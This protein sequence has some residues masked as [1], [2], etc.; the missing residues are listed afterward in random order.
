MSSIMLLVTIILSKVACSASNLL[1]P[2]SR[3]GLYISFPLHDVPL[4]NYCLDILYA[5]IKHQ[6][7]IFHPIVLSNNARQKKFSKVLAF[8][9]WSFC[10]SL[11][12]FETGLITRAKNE[13]LDYTLW[14][15]T[16]FSMPETL[17]FW[18]HFLG[19]IELFEMNLKLFVLISSVNPS[20]NLVTTHFCR[21]I[22]SYNPRILKESDTG[23][24]AEFLILKDSHCPDKAAAALK[25]NAESWANINTLYFKLH[26]ALG[27]YRKLN[28][29]T[30]YV[31][32]GMIATIFNLT[33]LTAPWPEALQ[34]CDH[35]DWPSENLTYVKVVIFFKN[36]ENLLYCKQ[37]ARIRNISMVSVVLSPLDRYTWG[38][39]L[40]FILIVIA[41]TKKNK[42]WSGLDIVWNFLAQPGQTNRK[43][44][45]LYFGLVTFV[46][47]QNYL[48]YLTSGITL[49]FEEILFQTNEN[50]FEGGY[51]LVV[52]HRFTGKLDRFMTTYRLSFQTSLPDKDPRKYFI[53]ASENE[54]GLDGIQAMTGWVNSGAILGMEKFGY[55]FRILAENDMNYNATCHMVP[56]PF[57][58]RYITQYARSHHS[59]AYYR[60]ISQ[61]LMS[62]F[63]IEWENLYQAENYRRLTKKMRQVRKQIV[64]TSLNEK[65]PMSQSILLCTILMSLT[66]PALVS[67]VIWNQISLLRRI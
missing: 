47:Q 30:Y 40:G 36:S 58:T 1:V 25:E 18:K 4:P 51:R 10:L 61:I 14:F 63:D 20:Q 59:L 54:K 2:S 17:K 16:A 43:S 39:F 31:L 7:S 28:L 56:E 5:Q 12:E 50:L 44:L 32:R 6:V 26:F 52:P 67:E 15:V 34:L 22:W 49:P 55:K 41:F 64:V 46:I 19:T 38:L 3:S 13:D 35:C 62:G 53:T 27:R 33:F 29:P 37:L 21:N 42:I 9:Y 48:S 23:E 24:L 11:E 60:L 57:S 45:A 65:T 8:T 66:I